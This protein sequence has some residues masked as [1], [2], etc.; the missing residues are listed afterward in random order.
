MNFPDFSPVRNDNSS[1]LQ[2]SGSCNLNSF[3][4][5]SNLM[6][7]LVKKL[8]I[9]AKSLPRTRQI[10]NNI[11][12]IQDLVESKKELNKHFS[13]IEEDFKQGVEALRAL[14]AQ[15]KDLTEQLEI[16]VSK[17]SQFESKSQCDLNIMNDLNDKNNILIQEN[18][19][20]K[21]AFKSY[22]NNNAELANKISIL[23]TQL[24]SREKQID[25]FVSSNSE[26]NAKLEVVK[27]E[28]VLLRMQLENEKSLEGEKKSFEATICNNDIAINSI[29]SERERNKK[30]I[31]EKIKHHYSGGIVEKDEEVPIEIEQ[32]EEHTPFFGKETQGSVKIKAEKLKN[33][34]DLVSN[35]MLKSLESPEN[36]N[37]L[38]KEF[39]NNFMDK[40]LSKDVTEE[41]LLKI[42]NFLKTKKGEYQFEATPRE[43]EE[44][45][46]NYETKIIR[47]ETE[48]KESD[49]VIIKKYKYN[50]LDRSFNSTKSLSKSKKKARSSSTGFLTKLE[51]GKS[52]ESSL[53][54]YR[55]DLAS[56]TGKNYIN[57]TNPY[58]KFFDKGIQSGGKSHIKSGK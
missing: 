37:I 50:K 13:E 30:I 26:L 33:K 41:Y 16:S 35:I 36:L 57:F 46:K 53:R 56:P 28:N 58:G 38:N 27:E 19:S 45:I 54:S 4:K 55:H 40:L 43:T 34:S 48:E 2:N 42:D 12:S 22:E 5:F 14:V 31:N 18:D 47:E 51:P 32:E 3:S 24:S 11:F 9:R 25:E 39:G 6:D 1:F 8:E 52:F 23:E 49:P 44:L 10:I 7:Y 20:L 29:L 15:N 17:S 21:Y